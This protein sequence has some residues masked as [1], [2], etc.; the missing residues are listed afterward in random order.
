MCIYYTIGLED[1]LLRNLDKGY[2][3]SRCVISSNCICICIFFCF[4]G[5]HPQH[6]EVPKLGVKSEP[7]PQPRR[8]HTTFA[9]YH[10]SQKRQILNPLS[11][12]RD[13][14]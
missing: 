12:A 14:T 1:V 13:G 5:L 8:I 2:I 6:M 9:T 7:Q 11:K 10:S 4:L 3:G